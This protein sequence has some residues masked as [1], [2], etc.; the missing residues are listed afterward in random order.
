LEDHPHPHP[1]PPTPHTH[2]HQV[3]YAACV[4]ARAFMAGVPPAA[5]P[6]FYPS[7]LPPMCLNRYYVAEGVR[8]YAQESW[9][10]AVG[11]RGRGLVAA[12][13]DDVVG[14]GLGGWGGLGLG[15]GVELGWLGWGFAWV[16]ASIGVGFGKGK[17][18][19]LG[20]QQGVLVNRRCR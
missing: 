20:D 4:A 18:C 10:R 5:A 8:L 9:R 2:H 12:H 19:V 7:L 17:G 1:Q 16:E 11:D 3:R 6:R 15:C 14:A 13:I